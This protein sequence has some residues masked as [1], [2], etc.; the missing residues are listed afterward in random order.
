MTTASAMTARTVRL[1]ALPLALVLRNSNQR[2]HA[3]G[4]KAMDMHA[5]NAVTPAAVAKERQSRRT[6]NHAAPTAKTGLVKAMA[7]Q[8]HGRR[9]LRTRATA[10]KPRTFPMMISGLHHRTRGRAR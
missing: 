9:K 4:S 6:K 10:R 1:P 3:L 2:L 8:A 5:T 7:D